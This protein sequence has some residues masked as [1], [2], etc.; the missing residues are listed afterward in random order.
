[1]PIFCTE[2]PQDMSWSPLYIISYTFAWRYM[3]SNFAILFSG[4]KETSF[5]EKVF[6]T[7]V[8]QLHSGCHGSHTCLGEV[9]DT[10]R[11]QWLG[12]SFMMEVTGDSDDWWLW[13][14]S[15]T[16]TLYN[17]IQ[18]LAYSWIINYPSTSLKWVPGNWWNP[19]TWVLAYCFVLWIIPHLCY[20][21]SW[22]NS[23][24]TV[25]IIISDWNFS[26]TGKM[27]LLLVS[28]LCCSCFL[29]ESKFRI[30]ETYRSYNNISLTCKTD[31]GIE[32][33]PQWWFNGAPLAKSRCY[34]HTSTCSSNGSVSVTVT[35][36]CEGEFKCSAQAMEVT[37]KKITP[38]RILGNYN[39]SQC[40]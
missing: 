12:E 35:P 24:R 20:K 19:P 6:F 5:I 15:F 29:A 4:H 28:L 31:T 22:T 37:D 36:E 13:Q 10:Y 14:S 27:L 21:Y 3:Q 11:H 2:M 17:Y 34:K 18:M 16:T 25:S 40:Q 39:Y 33:N 30:E 8:Y 26:T 7:S 23:Q 9:I 32:R 1:M 38:R